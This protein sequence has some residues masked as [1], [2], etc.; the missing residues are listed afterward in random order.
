MAVQSIELL[1]GESVYCIN[2]SQL[3]SA[4]ELAYNNASSSEKIQETLQELELKF[5]RN[6]RASLAFVMIDRLLKNPE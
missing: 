4:Y 5:T 6:E 3:Q 2:Q 1:G